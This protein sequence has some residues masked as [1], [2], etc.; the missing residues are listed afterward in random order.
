MSNREYLH[1][2]ILTLIP[3]VFSGRTAFQ[4]APESIV[5]SSVSD[6]FNVFRIAHMY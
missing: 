5:T 1:Y 6:E 3:E 4:L 2:V